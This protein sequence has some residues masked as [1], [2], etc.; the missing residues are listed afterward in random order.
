MTGQP[1]ARQSTIWT[2]NRIERVE[3][4]H[5]WRDNDGVLNADVQF[6]AAFITFRDPATAR[7]VAAACAQAA[8]AM[9][10]LP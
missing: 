6:G 7:N 9:E 10:T 2:S 8:D 3:F 1:P 4:G 5:A